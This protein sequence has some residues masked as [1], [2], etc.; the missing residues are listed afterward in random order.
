MA[1][2]KLRLEEEAAEREKIQESISQ[3]RTGFANVCWPT[4]KFDDRLQ[5]DRE[6]EHPS[7][8]IF[9]PVG[10]NE[11]RPAD[12]EKGNKHYRRYYNKPLEE[13][14]DPNGNPL[15]VSPFLTE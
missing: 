15:V 10:Y 5:V 14:L 11:K 3:S 8:Q 12:D 6:V 13:V 7:D 2:E 4:Y 1:E 9:F